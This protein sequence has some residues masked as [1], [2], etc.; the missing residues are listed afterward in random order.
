M[1]ANER[2]QPSNAYCLYNEDKQKL[3]SNQGKVHNLLL[4]QHTSIVKDR[5]KEEAD[6][7]VVSEAYDAIRIYELIEKYMLKQMESWYRYLTV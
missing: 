3:I 6:W 4:G 7:I 1:T 2:M 5:L